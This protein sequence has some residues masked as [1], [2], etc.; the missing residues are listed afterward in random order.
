[1]DTTPTHRSGSSM[2][3]LAIRKRVQYTH[4]H[5]QRAILY[6]TELK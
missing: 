1:M 3:P 5:T 6:Y 2:R 4:L